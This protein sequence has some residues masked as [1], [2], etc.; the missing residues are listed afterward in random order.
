MF[1]ELAEA[2][3]EI[4]SHWLSENCVTQAPGDPVHALAGAC[5]LVQPLVESA[6][7]KPFAPPRGLK[8][9]QRYEKKLRNRLHCFLWVGRALG[10]WRSLL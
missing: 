5:A 8:P 1:H 2:K 6:G 7:W 10:K 9:S 4:R 3:E